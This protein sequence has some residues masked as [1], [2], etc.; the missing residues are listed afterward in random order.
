[1]VQASVAEAAVSMGARE[2]NWVVLQNLH[3]AHDWL[4]TL[5]NL[6]SRLYATTSTTTKTH[7]RSSS[8]S[9]FNPGFRLILT[10]EPTDEVKM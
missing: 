10:S 6:I 4:P 1:M 8:A 9:A 3:H 5:A 7:S 2:G